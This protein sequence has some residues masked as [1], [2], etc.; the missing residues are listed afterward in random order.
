MFILIILKTEAVS[1]TRVKTNNPLESKPVVMFIAHYFT[2][3]PYVGG[4]IGERYVG[5]YNTFSLMFQSLYKFYWYDEAKMRLYEFV[6]GKYQSKGTYFL[7][8]VILHFVRE[9][10]MHHKAFVV[11]I[12][13]PAGCYKPSF[14]ISAS[15]FLLFRALGF[16]RLILDV[17]DVPAYIGREARRWKVP[18][19]FGHETL[20][21]M[22][23]SHLI[24]TSSAWSAYLLKRNAKHKEIK[25]IPMG[26]FHRLIRPTYRL[27]NGF[28]NL[29]YTGPLMPERGI[30]ELVK[31]VKRIREKGYGIR[32]LLATSSI[33]KVSLPQSEWLVA[34]SSVPTYRNFIEL[35]QKADAFVIPYPP[36]SYWDR[37]FIAKMSVYMAAGKPIISTN[38]CETK[39][40][41]RKW[42]CGLIALN[43]NEMEELIVKLLKDGRLALF[44]GKNA[45]IAAEKVYNW[46]ACAQTLHT[47]VQDAISS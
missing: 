11:I 3:F 19:F 43:W 36:N 30:M 9:G 17:I 12:P 20:C 45:R 2:R 16:M 46:E 25:I 10:I 42:N 6:N 15:S 28:F 32:L 41:L 1:G 23:A 26:S 14:L 33:S 40:I 18:F 27:E 4:P 35:L 38:L 7:P 24:V 34:F 13:Y 8:M 21:I 29:F 22:M 39:R 47:L 44:L 5:L 37:A 31:C